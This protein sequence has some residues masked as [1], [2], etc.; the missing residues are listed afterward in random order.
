MG[1]ESHFPELVCKP[2]KVDKGRGPSNWP[3]GV[4]G[5]VRGAG[6]LRATNSHIINQLRTGTDQGNL[7]V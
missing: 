1:P 5:W 4:G 3:T 2:T 7:T 6:P